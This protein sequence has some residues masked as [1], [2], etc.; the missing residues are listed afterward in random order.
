LAFSVEI[1]VEHPDAP[2]STAVGLQGGSRYV[3][4]LRPRQPSRHQRIAGGAASAELLSVKHVQI[5]V[6]PP[7]GRPAGNVGSCPC[8]NLF[9]IA[10]EVI[11]AVEKDA[12]CDAR[13]ADFVT[14][15][16]VEEGPEQARRS[17]R[18]RESRRR[19]P[20]AR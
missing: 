3:R 15:V 9:G 5:D 12:I 4:Q 20:P 6:Q 1:G 13:D 17:R 18:D 7:T 11:C 16:R 8:R 14:I 2:S 19:R 10:A